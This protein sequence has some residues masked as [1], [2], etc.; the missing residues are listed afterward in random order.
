MQIKWIEK[1]DAIKIGWSLKIDLDFNE[2]IDVVA[3][4]IGEPFE[5]IVYER[6]LFLQWNKAEG[7]W[8]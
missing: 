1:W 3:E 5:S 7:K 4:F 6:E 2:V 8:S